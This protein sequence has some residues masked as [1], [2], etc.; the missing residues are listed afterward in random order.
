VSRVLVA[1]CLL[2]ARAF[3][4]ASTAIPVE[5]FAP[6][7]GPSALLAG[8]GAATTPFAYVGA[9]LSLSWIADPLKL[10]SSTGLI[11]RPVT[12]MLTGD[13]SLEAGAWKRI[14]VGVGVPVVLYATGDRLQGTGAGDESALGYPSGGDLRLRAKASFVGDPTK[15]GFH[16]AF[17][18]QL[19]VPLDGDSQFAASAGVT[20]EPRLI[21]DYRWNRLLVVAMLGV[22]FQPERSLFNTTFGDEITWLAGVS[23]RAWERGRFHLDGLLEAG[24]FAGTTDGTRP[25][26]LRGGIRTGWGNFSLD[27][28]AGGGLTQDAASPSWRFVAVVRHAFDVTR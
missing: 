25:A 13:A 1:L 8:E 2:T 23:V 19:T 20:G 26:E 21:A 12:G 28:A 15:N 17:L 3:A 4:D 24:G 18:L 14:S 10:S 9:T 7:Q 16:L 6:G 27:V 11:S 5:R 22:H